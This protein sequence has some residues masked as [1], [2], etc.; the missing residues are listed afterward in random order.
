MG[1]GSGPSQWEWKSRW[2]QQFL[3]RTYRVRYTYLC[4]P[5]LEVS[6]DGKMKVD[7][8]TNSAQLLLREALMTHLWVCMAPC[9]PVHGPQRSIVVLSVLIPMTRRD[10][11]GERRPSSLHHNFAE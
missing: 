9:V 6:S 2:K 3:Q 11:S 1:L 7:G 8:I 5:P 10:H 4:F